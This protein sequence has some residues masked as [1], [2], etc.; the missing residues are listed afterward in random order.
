ML[1][2]DVLPFWTFLALALAG[3]LA[4]FGLRILVKD[5]QRQQAREKQTRYDRFIQLFSTLSQSAAIGLALTLVADLLLVS[6]TSDARLL[7]GLTLLI[8]ALTS[9]AAA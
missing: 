3:I 7:A 8:A 6:R 9:F 1:L 2:F 4:G 5:R